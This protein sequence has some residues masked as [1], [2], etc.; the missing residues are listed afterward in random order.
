MWHSE[1][2]SNSKDEPTHGTS[3]SE[4]LLRL[5]ALPADR[6]ALA[7]LLDASGDVSVEVARE[8]LRRLARLGGPD[9]AQVLRRRIWRADP[10]LVGELAACIAKLG[11]RGAIEE[12]L[13]VL[14]GDRGESL[15]YG[16]RVAAVR[17]LA[18]F[19]DPA[20]VPA[21]RDALSDPI[22]PVRRAALVALRGFPADTDTDTDTDTDSQRAVSEC[23]SDP[24]P[25]VRAAAVACVAALCPDAPDRLAGVARDESASVRLAL[26]RVASRLAQTPTGLLLSDSEI[27]VREV[28]AEHAGPRAIAPLARA[29]RL[30]HSPAVRLAAARRLGELR[31]ASATA[32]LIDALADR[33]S[34]VKVTAL[35]SLE[36]IHDREPLADLLFDAACER[37]RED[38][39]ALVYALGRLGAAER[40]Q[41]LAQDRD[42]QVRQA[43]AFIE[44]ESRQSPNPSS[45]AGHE[46]GS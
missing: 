29:M 27:S 36:L 28:A 3:A 40:L 38:R 34:L 2:G 22:A 13:T 11:D 6:S 12:A 37:S 24:D 42:P 35:R 23:L 8:A 33:D 44:R 21:L 31:A 45:S 19:G 9:E 17:L 25:Q 18:A 20:S 41:A 43:L 16:Q 26:A 1:R 7:E 14:R 32:E 46:R 39:G 15:T 10:S 4:R 30:D 5:R